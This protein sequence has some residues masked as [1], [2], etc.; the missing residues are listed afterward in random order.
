MRL[1]LRE[2]VKGRPHRR[3][4]YEEAHGPRKKGTFFPGKRMPV[5]KIN[6]KVLHSLLLKD[7][8]ILSEF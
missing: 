5:T 6:N 1:L 7:L 8:N 4:A 3:A 2:R